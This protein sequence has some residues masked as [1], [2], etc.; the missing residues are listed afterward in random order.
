VPSIVTVLPLTVHTRRQRSEGHRQVAARR[1]CYA[2]G[3]AAHVGLRRDR[4]E[5]D[6]LRAQTHEHDV[7]AGDGNASRE[8]GRAARVIEAEITFGKAADAARL[9]QR[10]GRAAGNRR[11]RAIA[12]MENMRSAAGLAQRAGDDDRVRSRRRSAQLEIDRAAAPDQRTGAQRGDGARAAAGGDRAACRATAPATLPL[13][14]SV[15]PLTVTAPE[16]VA[17][18]GAAVLANKVPAKIVVPPL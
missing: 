15:P 9:D 5:G 6:R 12:E 2:E 14:A 11:T 3:A 4:R 10:V 8:A 17:L 7:V 18:S 1:G 13:P 16:P